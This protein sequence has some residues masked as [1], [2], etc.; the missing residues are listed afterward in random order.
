MTINILQQRLDDYDC[1]S[2]LDEEN[3][4]KE[5][6]Q[7][8]AL[9]ALSRSN[10]FKYATFHGGTSL[11]ILYG[12]PRFSE[13]LDF[14]LLQPNKTFTWQPYQKRLLEEFS[15]FGLT[16]EMVE[17]NKANETIKKAFL[18]DN[19]FGRVLQLRFPQPEKS[20]KK[21]RIKLEIDTNPPM[22]A[23]NTI[24]YLDFPLPFS[25]HVQELP[26][27]FAG[28]IH[29][30]LC[31]SYIK[32]RDWYDFNWYIMRKI[33]LNYNY[34]SNALDQI[35]PWQKQKPQVDDNW[36]LDALNKRISELDWDQARRDV[37]RF[38]KPV[39]Q[40]SLSLWSQSYF[41]N[42]LKKLATYL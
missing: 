36:L 16:L 21:I 3:A 39:E 17:R 4:K 29:A 13:D 9:M 22:G 26:T 15:S 6:T 1:R 5:I 19:S 37:Q 18:K 8:I 38:I 11:R 40:P 30:L 20:Q 25:I 34:L 2:M 28:K 24:K 35:G 31:R 27:L 23:I 41:Q 12:L 14:T 32:G 7:E 10:F 42:Q 33:K